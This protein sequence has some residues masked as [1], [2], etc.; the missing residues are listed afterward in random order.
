[1]MNF[2]F[3]HLTKPI[4]FKTH[5]TRYW[6]FS[7]LVVAAM[8]T[9][10]QGVKSKDAVQNEWARIEYGVVKAVGCEVRRIIYYPL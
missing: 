3:L 8:M 6:L 4:V 5:L 10:A 1:M 7:C 9:Q 2:S